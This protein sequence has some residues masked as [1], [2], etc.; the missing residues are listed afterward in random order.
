VFG[1][2]AA[3]QPSTMDAVRAVM[4]AS[5]VGVV[6]GIAQDARDWFFEG[7]VTDHGS[8]FAGGPGGFPPALAH[9]QTADALG[10]ITEAERHAYRLATLVDTTTVTAWTEHDSVRARADLAETCRLAG[11]AVH[12]LAA[13]NGSGQIRRTVRALDDATRRVL[14]MVQD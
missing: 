14:S 1:D 12:I 8:S 11:D 3:R 6:V 2:E 4:A 5:S 7:L 10:M 13:T 9:V